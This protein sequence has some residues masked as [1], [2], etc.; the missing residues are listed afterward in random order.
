MLLPGILFGLAA[1]TCQSLSYL[2]S[3]HFVGASRERGVLLLLLAHLIQG[4][5]CLALL[6]VLWPAT[7]PPW[8]QYAV[9]IVVES[10][11]YLVGQ[12]CL[13][14]ALRRVEASRI[15]PVLSFKIAIL[16]ILSQVLLGRS[17]TGQQWLAVLLAVA[18]AWLLQWSGGRFTPRTL[19]TVL[20]GCT[21]YAISDLYIRVAIERM[22][23]VPPIQAALTAC[24]LSYAFCGLAVLPLWW[25]VRR[26]RAADVRQATPYALTW[27]TSMG[28]LYLCFGLA[29]VILGNIVQSSRG[30]ISILVGPWLARHRHWGHLE[31]VQPPHAIARRAACALLMV[32]AVALYVLGAAP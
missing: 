11:G 24:A 15:A 32:A 28:F 27:L 19:A 20:L 26:V 1:A 6:P 4:L 23:P 17:I 5:I 30:L 21:G 3:R 14:A 10:L 8:R 2:Q 9:P 13:F 25:W 16:A 18:A 29:G 22:A 7:M 12:A 31:S